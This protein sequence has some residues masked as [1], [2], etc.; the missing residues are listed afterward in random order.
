MSESI[1]YVLICKNIICHDKISDVFGILLF[2]RLRRK[3]CACE[4]GK[5]DEPTGDNKFRPPMH[6]PTPNQ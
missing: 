6:R 5:Q 2:G 3:L 4:A 1:D